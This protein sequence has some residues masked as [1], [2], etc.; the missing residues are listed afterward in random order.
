[1][2]QLKKFYMQYNYDNHHLFIQLQVSNPLVLDF[3]E[4]TYT[5]Q[6]REMGMSVVQLQQYPSGSIVETPLIGVEDVHT[7][8]RKLD[9][10]VATLGLSLDSLPVSRLASS[11]VALEILKGSLSVQEEAVVTATAIL[12][13]GRRVLIDDPSKLVINTSNSSIV[14]VVNNK[15]V[16]VDVG[17]AFINVSWL[18][19]CE[20]VITTETVEVV[21]SI[22]LSQPMF[23]PDTQTVQ[24]PED[25]PI[26]FPVAVVAA[27]LQAED[28][29]AGSSPDVQYRFKNG[30][31]F[32]GLFSL[33]PTSGEIHLNGQL[34]RES[35]D[36]Y[37]LL[38]EATNSAQRRAE[39]GTTQEGEDDDGNGSGSGDFNGPLMPDET[40]DISNSTVDIAVL[41]VSSSECA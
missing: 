1:M 4:D 6:G 9:P 7:S 20:E 14:A 38:V 26:G 36:A 32:N 28:G 5:V 16:G 30:Q 27:I 3:N 11:T 2:A 24:V 21:V 29:Q 23:V 25:S 37:T 13:D 39:M 35:L 8:L 10:I 18:N 19:S 15:V 41:T 22:D 12:E 40:P 33:N 17:V 31:N 34:D